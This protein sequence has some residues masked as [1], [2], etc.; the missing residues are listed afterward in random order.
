MYVDTYIHFQ[1]DGDISEIKSIRRFFLLSSLFVDT[2]PAQRPLFW[3][4]EFVTNLTD[5]FLIAFN[6][7]RSPWEVPSPNQEKND[8]IRGRL[9][10]EKR[11]I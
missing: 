7:W 5:A 3:I 1:R 11:D 8:S 2:R 10:C 6:K 9:I 4:I